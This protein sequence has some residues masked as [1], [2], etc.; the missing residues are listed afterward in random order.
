MMGTR[1][2]TGYEWKS[3]SEIERKST[4]FGSGLIS[5]DMVIQEEQE[6]RPLSFL[7]IYAKNRE[8]WIIGDIASSLF[9][10]CVVP[11]YD[12]LGAESTTYIL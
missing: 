5:M 10:F 4:N 11:F 3:Y 12:T 8:E 1:S 9:N 2:A 6:G 7:G